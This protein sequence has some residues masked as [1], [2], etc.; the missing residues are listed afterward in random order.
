MTIDN[1]NDFTTSA[2]SSSFNEIENENHLK[3]VTISMIPK[4]SAQ[5]LMFNACSKGNQ[6]HV[7][8]DL[9]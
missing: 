6:Y 7:I 1:L 2:T 9:F 8:S 4:K 5:T 3:Y